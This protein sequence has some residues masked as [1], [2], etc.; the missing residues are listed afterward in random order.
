MREALDLGRALLPGLSQ[1]TI[2]ALSQLAAIATDQPDPDYPPAFDRFR[3]LS[4]DRA[5]D[6]ALIA[7]RHLESQ[8]AS[9][10]RLATKLLRNLA[11]FRF[12]PFDSEICRSLREKGTFWPAYL[13]RDAGDAKAHALLPMLEG[14]DD[15]LR[16]DHLLLCLSW[17]RSSLAVASFRG[18][19]RRRLMGMDRICDLPSP[20]R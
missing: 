20:Y 10:R 5:R 3:C 14:A 6:V 13:Y 11:C 2:S 1:E 16:A 8:A 7:L 15:S 12:E 17:T 19:P 4:A 9:V 18:L